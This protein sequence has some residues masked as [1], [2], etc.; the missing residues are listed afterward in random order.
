MQGEL[1]F[2]RQMDKKSWEAIFL[3]RESSITG[4]VADEL[5]KITSHNG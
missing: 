3:A 5:L 2:A 1:P 4:R